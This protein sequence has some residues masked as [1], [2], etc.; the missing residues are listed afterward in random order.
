M[1]KAFLREK[2]KETVEGTKIQFFCRIRGE[3]QI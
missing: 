1:S 3:D 2:L